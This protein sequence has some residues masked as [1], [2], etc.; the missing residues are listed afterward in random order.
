[1]PDHV[2]N[3]IAAGEVVERPSSVVKE[4]MENALDAGAERIRVEITDGGKTLMRVSDDGS[5]MSADDALCALKRH[6]TSKVG[7]ASDLMAI[8]TLGFRGEALPSIRSVSRFELRT[9]LHGAAE[10]TRI[11][12][13]GA[14]EPALS[15]AGGPPGTEITVAD[16]FFNVPARRKFLRRTGTELARISTLVE[17]LALGWPGVHFTLHHNGRKTA[18]YPADRDLRARILAV[19]GRKACRGLFP[20]RLEMGHHLVRGYVSGPND[21]RRSASRMFTYINGR[22]VRD[23]VIQ[24][25]IIQ[26]YGDHLERGRYPVCVLY[27]SLPPAAVDVNVHPTKAE[28]RF[29]ESG[30]THSLV[31]RALRLG[32]S[33]LARDAVDGA[34]GLQPD[35]AAAAPLQ[36]ALAFDSMAEANA[37]HQAR[38][39]VGKPVSQDPDPAPIASPT[40]GRASQGGGSAA[41]APT[42][43]LGTV[44]GRYLVCDTDQGVLFVDHVALVERLLYDGLCEALAVGAAPG[45]RLLFPAQIE[46]SAAQVRL[47]Q[48]HADVLAQLGFCLEPFGGR[49]FVL[50]AIPAAVRDVDPAAALAVALEA[51]ESPDPLHGGCRG[52]ARAGAHATAL[53]GIHEV[54]ALLTALRSASNPDRA[55]DGRAISVVHSSEVIEAW[56]R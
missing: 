52:L 46:L 28:V 38:A 42:R 49:A 1:M 22:Y 25:A 2:A 4:L 33:D 53:P 27:L 54:P 43:V 41:A 31:E 9:R 30:A 29:V 56:F 47:A 32:L 19:L 6:A 26:A 3:Q 8:D 7:E 36:H 18:D 34:E 23:R 51:V 24:H 12:A 20:V 11:V 10:G 55:P 13:H 16:L 44:G 39:E 15:P 14:E 5:G 17:Q 35:A 48:L 37:A 40:P 50:S 45:Q 21:A